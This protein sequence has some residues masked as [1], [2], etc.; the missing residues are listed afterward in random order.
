MI[1][2]FDVP[3][4]NWVNFVNTLNRH[5]LEQPVRLEVVDREL[6][7]QEL[8]DLQPLRG[9]FFETKGSDRGSFLLT[10]GTDEGEL[11][12][13]IDVPKRLYVGH[14]EG[15]EMEFLGIDEEP[16]GT[17]I[18]YFEHLAALPENVVHGTEASHP[19]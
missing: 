11:T 4:E 16:V 13:R 3:K 6:G 5:A 7:D 9:L 19:T 15:Q 8:E 12:H 17:T 2:T 10:V 14:N 1:H 18:I